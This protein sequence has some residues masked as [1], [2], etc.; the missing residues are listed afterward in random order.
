MNIPSSIFVIGLFATSPAPVEPC[1]DSIE[2][3]ISKANVAEDPC[4]EH[5]KHLIA[6]PPLCFDPLARRN[7]AEAHGFPCLIEPIVFTQNVVDD[8]ADGVNSVFAIDLDGDGDMD[9]LSASSSSDTIAW[10][11]NDQSNLGGS[12][13]GFTTHVLTESANAARSVFAADL[14]GD[15]H[16]DVVAGSAIDGT[17]AWF[18]SD[19][20]QPPA[21]TQHVIVTGE[22][23]VQAVYAID[24]DGDDDVDVLSAASGNDTIAWYENGGGDSPT[25]TRR[26][27]SNS[28]D[29]ARHVFAAD[30]DGDGDIDVLSASAFDATVAWHEN[31][32][33][34]PPSFSRRVITSTAT[35]AASVFAGDLDGDF[36]IDVIAAASDIDRVMWFENDGGVNPQFTEHVVTD[37]Q[38][39]PASVFIADMDGD[40]ARDLLVA[41]SSDDS[42]AWY[43]NDGG[44]PPSFNLI[45]VA[46]ADGARSV[47]AADVDGDFVMDMVAGST[48]DD[49]V[50]WYSP[51]EPPLG[52]C[53]LP[54]SSCLPD[55]CLVDCADL[56]AWSWTEGGACDGMECPGESTPAAFL[57]DALS[58]GQFKINIFQLAALGTR[59]W[60][61]PGNSEALDIIQARFE[62]YGYDN[63]VRDPYVFQGQTKHNIYVTKIG[64]VNPGQMYI[65]G[66]HMDSIHIGGPV[67]D[68]PGADD[69]A[70]GTSSVLEMARVFARARTDVSIRFILWNN[71]ETGLNGS[72]AYVENHR[73]LQGTPDEPQ[74]LG[75]IQQDMILYDR[76]PEPDADIEF[77][78][79]ANAGGR[80]NIFAEFIAGAMSRYGTMAAEVGDNMGFTDSV[81]FQ[82]DTAAVSVRENQRVAEIGNGANPH[83]H[84]PTDLFTTYTE[85]DYEFGFNIVKMV[86]GSLG[87]LSGAVIVGD[88]DEDGD[89]DLFDFQGFIGC[90]S[91]PGGGVIPGCA[92]FD[93]NNDGDVDL[94]DL[95]AFQLLFGT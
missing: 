95:G 74:W 46:D 36:D 3:I 89:V 27:V 86:C 69:D 52:A 34:T 32:G 25:F 90:Q 24:L 77:Q 23:F 16:L 60:S 18:E 4:A 5:S 58:L 50:A 22:S 63:V 87:E 2:Q 30:I 31:D 62:S 47:V 19:G 80:A 17:I 82:N 40:G 72:E 91:A 39:G 54:N 37:Q 92:P 9:I 38:D 8:A 13:P 56:L 1:T 45:A 28:S 7:Y 44:A 71:E 68:A 67:S 41:S 93:I 57:V 94:H 14:D 61:L 76:L 20:Q 53:C 70:S 75:M 66:A 35:G 73:D 33:Q 64:T 65:V 43:A 11:E 88:A 15:T 78:I 48:F 21:F 79:N 59:Y 84:Q 26:V 85:Q 51:H 42:I 10:Y 12:P 29:S 6:Q 81:P 55:T 49:T 83:W